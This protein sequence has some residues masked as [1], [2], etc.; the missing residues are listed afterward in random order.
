M[1]QNIYII[2]ASGAA[3]EVANY[4]LDIEKYNFVA[5]IDKDEA[6]TVDHLTI[7]DKQ[8]PIIKEKTFLTDTKYDNALGAIAIGNPYLREK[9]A[10][11]FEY[12]L[13]FPNIIHPSVNRIDTSIILGQGNIF[14][15]NC[16][17]TT[18]LLIG[19]FN[20]LNIGVIIGHDANIGSY[21]VFNTNAVISGN[22]TIENSC[23]LGTNSAIIQG[24]KI[25]SNTTIGIGSTVIKSI[26]K[27]GTYMG[28]PARK[29]L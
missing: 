17:L 23:L 16:T 2:G 15:P 28:C 14:S 4:I 18:N 20:F 12:K 8:Y 13:S 22:V 29:I 9:I 5:F 26:K 6:I 25:I 10:T 24:K 7:R 1:Q 19:S 3:L 27:P 11:K 21:N